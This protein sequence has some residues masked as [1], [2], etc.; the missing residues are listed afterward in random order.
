M[1]IQA[2]DIPARPPRQRGSTAVSSLL[3]F[4]ALLG[5]T[6]WGWS[7]TDMS[8]AANTGVVLLLWVNAAM[9]LAMVAIESGRRPYSLHLMHLLALFLFTTASG[10]FQYTSGSFAVSGPITSFKKAIPIAVMAV[11]LWTIGYIVAYE[12]T[13]LTKRTGRGSLTRLLNREIST[14]R[15]FG[16]MVIGILSVLYLAAIGLAG[17]STRGAARAAT[18]QFAGIDSA[19]GI[20]G[21]GTL[22]LGYFLIHELL[23]RALSPFALLVGMLLFARH[24]PARNPIFLAV[25]VVLGLGTLI[26]NNP[27]AASRMWLATFMISLAAPFVLKRMRTGWALVGITLFGLSVLP[28][29]HMSRMVETLGEFAGVFEFVSPFDYLRSNFDVDALGTLSVAQKWLETHPHRFGMQILGGLF[30]WVPRTLWPSKP[31][32]TGTMVTSGMGFDFTNISVPIPAEPLVDFGLLGVAPVGALFGTLL[33]RLDRTYWDGA[34][35]GSGLRLI[36]CTYP[37]WPGCIIF[38]TRGGFGN[39]LAFTVCFTVWIVP[40]GIWA[41]RSARQ[42]H[43]EPPGK[44]GAEGN[45]ALPAGP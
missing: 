18:E 24:K 43:V 38:L 15:V 41:A 19:A 29:L 25:L 31:I 14:G 26:A 16:F 3:L 20:G 28:G 39:A 32:S 17:A 21:G 40:L 23:L 4:V 30:F 13:N 35:S 27:F 8:P 36:D 6:I 34:F 7:V 5:M 2:T 45:P 9:M 44:P 42:Q 22:G 12:F 10:L 37:F 33:A 11:T 1:N